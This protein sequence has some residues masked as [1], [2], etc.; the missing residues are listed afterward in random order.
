MNIVYGAN[1]GYAK[2][3][4]ISLCS[5]LEHNTREDVIN[6]YILSTGISVENKK[7]LQ[8]LVE[9]YRR[10]LVIVEMGNLESRFAGDVL[11][12]EGERQDRESEKQT[13]EKQFL[14]DEGE[15]DRSRKINTGG[16]DISIMSRL[17]M[18]DVLPDSVERVLY[19]DCD[20]IILQS[21]HRLWEVN[22]KGAVLG[23]V[24]EPTI[25]D[26]VKEQIGLNPQEPYYNS[27]VLLIDL[28]R[29]REE[30]VQQELVEYFLG[31]NGALGFG[32]QDTINAVLRGKIRTLSPRY[33]FFSNY[34]YFRY[35]TLVKLLPAYS[36]CPR[37]A[38]EEAKRHPAVVHFA[39][40]ER[41]WRAGNRNPYR[42]AYRKYKR[43]TVWKDE[44]MEHGKE[45]YMEMY[46]VMNLATWVC[47][48]FRGWISRK[49]G[50]KAVEARKEK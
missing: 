18:G 49:F 38:W 19:L 39:G 20:T 45:L 48:P 27:G 8:E 5:L 10:N 43:M 29:W 33:N 14:E 12:M 35:D 4:G 15:Y 2:H 31:H 44:E 36:C 24:M 9:K 32:D 22:L 3:L 13:C 6:I 16:F 26:S 47:P 1:D 7:N 34:R 25:Y 11:N 42:L 41:P 23:A 17:F 30:N 46:H 50:Q 21:L 28:K 40:D 37:A